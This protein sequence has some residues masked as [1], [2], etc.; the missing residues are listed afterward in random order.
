MARDA[1]CSFKRFKGYRIKKDA[2]IHGNQ[3]RDLPGLT[4]AGAAAA[5]SPAAK[6]EVTFAG[7]RLAPAGPPLPPDREKIVPTMEVDQGAS[8]KGKEAC[9]T[10]C[11][12][13]VLGRNLEVE[14]YRFPIKPVLPMA[15]LTLV[16]K[17]HLLVVSPRSLAMFWIS[18]AYIW[19][20]V[21]VPLVLTREHEFS[22]LGQ[23]D[24]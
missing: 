18:L 22:V 7:V 2:G 14:M 5:A 8:P 21:L 4:L 10:S 23:F 24:S 11:Q 3:M 20:L 12:F 1:T 19:L 15:H 9:A 16:R 6:P 17:G 13:I